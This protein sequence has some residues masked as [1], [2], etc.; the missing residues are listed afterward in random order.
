MP[1]WDKCPGCDDYV[2]NQHG[3]HAYDCPCPDIDTFAAMNINPYL[4]KV[5][6]DA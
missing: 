2:C 3:Q 6:K 4:D 5:V 1:M